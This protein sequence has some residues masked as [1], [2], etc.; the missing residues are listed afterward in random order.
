[1]L[2]GIDDSGDFEND[3][4]SLFAC[5]YMRAKKKQI[6]GKFDSW[7]QSLPD[8]ALNEKGELKGYLLS[9][10][11]IKDFVN[12]IL[13][14][15]GY[16]KMRHFV[17]LYNNSPDQ[18]TKI[19]NRR[20]ISLE[21]L[22]TAVN[23]CQSCKNGDG[24]NFY[25]GMYYWLKGLTPKSARKLELLSLVAF[26]AFRLAPVAG[27]RSGHDNDLGLLEINIDESII[28]KPQS[29]RYWEKTLS[30]TFWS[31]STDNRRFFHSTEWGPRHPYV[32]RFIKS[33]PTDEIVEYTNEASKCMSFVDSSCYPEVQIA[34]ILANIY[35]RYHNHGECAK[36]IQLLSKY[37]AYKEAVTECDFS[38]VPISHHNKKQLNHFNYL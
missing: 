38:D 8:S 13:L 1:M 3:A 16:G 21:Q 32:R 11:Q 2:V 34:D 18:K 4:Y 22:H 35:Y 33:S 19:E 31:Y 27:V 37:P 23:K 30:D 24:S 29:K 25:N 6:R 14:N 20:K 7:K 26:E 9:E 28:S 36:I 10:E 5:V 12:Q 17:F 15:N